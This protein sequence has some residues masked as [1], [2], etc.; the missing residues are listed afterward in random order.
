MW[1]RLDSDC[2]ELRA[3]D[4]PFE[5]SARFDLR[6]WKPDL[7]ERFLEFVRQI[8]GELRIAPDGPRVAVETSAFERALKASDAA[9][10]VADPRA[11][12][13]QLSR[14]RGQTQPSDRSGATMFIVLGTYRFRAA[15]VAFRNDF[16]IQCQAERTAICVRTLDVVHV[17][18]LP[19]LP[20]GVFKRWYCST[21]GQRPELARTAR[22]SIKVLALIV[23]SAMAA[24][25]WLAPIRNK[26]DR[27]DAV[28]WGMR[29]GSGVGLIAIARWIA[30]G[31]DDV[32]RRERLAALQSS[33]A[34]E[35]P[36]CSVHLIPGSPWQCPSCGM[37]R[38]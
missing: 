5:I 19:L 24:L 14:E 21:C 34:L 16:C 18:W 10:F 22:R 30:G 12:L 4:T 1:G 25:L 38:L 33:D 35:C 36:V 6:E 23:V 37:V 3:D 15:R 13:D 20:V 28:I 2:I 8:D 27:V 29:I 7:Y 32:V 31:S 26:E 11:F 17:F 9:R